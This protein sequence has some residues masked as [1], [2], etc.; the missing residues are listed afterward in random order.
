MK[1]NEPQISPLHQGIEPY[2]RAFHSVGAI[3]VQHVFVLVNAILSLVVV[4]LFLFGETQAAFF[5][6]CIFVFNTLIGIVQDFQ[7]RVALERLQLLT[8]QRVRRIDANGK[9]LLVPVRALRKGDRIKVWLGEQI[10]CDGTV[11]T[12]NALE[13]SEALLT[14]ES[15]SFPRREGASIQAG[16]IVTSGSGV[17]AVEEVWA[18]S[19]ISQMTKDARQYVASPSP[20]ERSTTKIISVSG[21]FL[22]FAIGVVLVRGYLTHESGVAI[23]NHIGALASIIVPQGLIVITT[24]LFAF[25]AA[26][27]ARKHVLFQEINATEKLG[28]IKNLCMDK[29][30]TLTDNTLSV[31]SI[32]VPYGVTKE[33]LCRYTSIYVQHSGDRSSTLFATGAYLGTGA[34]AEVKEAISFSS[35]RQFGGVRFDDG[36]REESVLVG[37]P[38][39]FLPHLLS[40]SEEAWLTER[41]DTYAQKG[42]R[43][44]CVVRTD[45]GLIPRACDGKHLFVVG[46]FVFENN[47]REGIR[48]AIAFFQDRGVRIRLLS[49]DNPVTVRAVALLA[50]LRGTESVITGME[51]ESWNEADYR[52]AAD[53]YTIFARVTPEQK[54]KL[55]THF[56]KNGFTA[57]VGDGANDA[58]A[59]KRA[60]LGIAM[61]DGAPATRQLAGVVLMNNSFTA[62]PGAVRLADNF[63][64][65]IEIFASIFLNQSIL[66]FYFFLMVT[67][68]GFPF[69]LTPLNV[70]LVN[71]F[72][73]G[74]PGIL[75][76]YW[77]IRPR[78]HAPPAETS[79]FAKRVLP[80]PI[81][82]GFVQALGVLLVFAMSPD[83]LKH[84]TSHPLVMYAFIGFGVLYLAFAPGVYGTRMT[85]RQKEEVVLVAI[86]EAI[87]L[88]ALLFFPALLAFFDLSTLP[89]VWDLVKATVIVLLFG[90]FLYELSEWRIGRKEPTRRVA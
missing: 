27:Y 59:I 11:L 65:N 90:S 85:R 66:G 6:G 7:A 2:L 10:P 80:F 21:Y 78:K 81:R 30:G 82:A 51:M 49:G 77:A 89:G 24:L 34:K 38:D 63:I 25:G 16:D 83:Y 12:S 69:P 86:V 1:Q 17:I 62:L 28:R 71:Y 76:S 3:V 72:A 4:L 29:T 19:R 26:S 36:D 56:K 18:K 9:E 37:S 45:D 55:I 8:A 42:K 15:D 73:V 60:D 44:L 32:H 13:V 67:F 43:V 46:L 53:Q 61:F 54:V 50:G 20:I 41:V 35:W 48:E 74:I 31:E 84:A 64:G 22:L 52:R 40:D 23:V 58:L 79:A 75:I 14:G 68:F 5:L 47:L 39:V 87:L 57:M 88:G 33:K 70:T